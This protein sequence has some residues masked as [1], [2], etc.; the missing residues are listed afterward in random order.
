M[1]DSVYIIGHKG[2][3]GNMYI[4]LFE[5]KNIKYYYSN[6][7]GE[8]DEIKKDI[9]EKNPSHVLCCM[10]R[11]HGTRD[12][13]EYTTIDYLQDNS[14]LH[15]NIND[16]LFVPL[17]LALFCDKNNIHFTYMGT[18]CIYNYNDSHQI[19]GIGFTET[20]KPNFF[21]S[22]YSTVKGHTNELMKYT[23]ALTLRIRMPITSCQ[24]PR[25]FIKKITTYEYICSI[26]NSMSVLDELLPVSIQMMENRETG[27]Y[28]LTNPN[29]ISHNKILEL[30]RDIVDP[31]FTWK[32]FDIN[33]QDKVLSSKRSNNLLDTTKLTDKYMVNDIDTAVI[34]VLHNMKVN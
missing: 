4:Q 18:G 8:S 14:V 24:S 29:S 27:I 15:Q 30:Y 7:R 32:N 6:Y 28:N 3:I 22:N 25:N 9:L 2:W 1:I 11:T 34:K 13:V 17:S 16:N 12:G 20:D 33:D 5:Q 10:G 26:E 19:N 21:G 23:N 31:T